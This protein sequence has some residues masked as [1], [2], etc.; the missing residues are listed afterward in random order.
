MKTAFLYKTYLNTSSYKTQ[1][2]TECLLCVYRDSD[3][4]SSVPGDRPGTA[5]PQSRPADTGPQEVTV[6]LVGGRTTG[7]LPFWARIHKTS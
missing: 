7:T 4:D 5:V 1:C 3:G 6:W 2:M